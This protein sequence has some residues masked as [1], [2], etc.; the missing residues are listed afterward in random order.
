MQRLIREPLVHFVLIAVVI[1]AAY[2]WLSDSHDSD[3]QT[4][5]VSAADL[6]RMAA[7]FTSEAGGLPNQQDMQAM[8]SDHVEQQALT[9]EARRLGLAEG[10]TVVERRLA[11]KMAFMITDME[12]VSEPAPGELE[13]WFNTNQA[14]FTEP[15]RM[16]FQHV[17]FAEAGDARL[18]DTRDVLRTAPETWRSQGDP[19]MLQRAYSDLPAREIARLFGAEFAAVL[20]QIPADDVDWSPPIQSALGVHFVRITGRRQGGLSDLQ[21]IRSQVLTRWQEEQSRAAARAAVAAIVDRYTVEIE[22]APAP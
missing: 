6:D 15:D 19:F 4:I 11:Q 13:D 9:R 7:L 12:A 18:D 5:V 21:A 16:S 1:F 17:F 8:V 22:G 3:A 20:T 2:G 14:Q 10:D